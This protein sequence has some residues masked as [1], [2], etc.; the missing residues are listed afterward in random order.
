MAVT[1][2]QIA[3]LAGVSRRTVDRALNNKDRVKP[4]VAEKIKAIAKNLNY[5]P[6]KAG[7]ALALA[8]KNLKIGVILQSANTPFMKD[9]LN[10]LYNAK[11]EV[12][13]LG[14][15]VTIHK[16][17]NVN[18]LEVIETMK[19]MYENN[20][21]GIALTPSDDIALTEIINQYI[22][23]YNIPV[24]TFNTDLVNT[25]RLCFIGQ[26]SLTA[27]KTAAGLIASLINK[28]GKIL[29]LSSYKENPS[30]QNRIHGFSDEIITNYP[31]IKIINTMYYY[32]DDWV[33]QKIIEDTLLKYPDLKGIYITGC[34]SKVFQTV[35]NQ[36]KQ[37]QI[38]I[39]A[40]DLVDEN[41][42]W[43]KQDVIDFLIDQD[44][45]SQGYKSIMILFKKLFDDVTPQEEFYYTDIVI[46]NKYNI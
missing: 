44:G 31:N 38:K 41:I 25:K 43:L 18:S 20:I 16:I 22:S 3:D 13:S 9:V 7:R 11:K 2:Q 5:Q 4:E 6:S 10:G 34:S 1:L 21:N 30:L 36:K 33:A 27:G 19:H 42:Y 23:E 28:Q 24:I 17:N 35:Y 39:V 8:K 32:E 15:N 40:N 29:I 37:E 46:K 14:A 26:D 12:E 45:Y